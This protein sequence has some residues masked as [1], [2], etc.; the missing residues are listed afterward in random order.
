MGDSLI[1]RSEFSSELEII[2][3]CEYK[4]SRSKLKKIGQMSRLI[5]FLATQT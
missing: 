1:H 2:F 3:R 4:Q 5:L